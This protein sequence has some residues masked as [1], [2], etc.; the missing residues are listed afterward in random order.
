MLKI[1]TKLAEFSKP[2]RSVGKAEPYFLP[3][4]VLLVGFTAFGLGRLSVLGEGSPRLIIHMPDGTTQAA[5]VGKTVNSVVSPN[6]ATRTG[7]YVA[8]KSGTKY[9][10]PSCAGAA[11]IKEGNRVWFATVAEA[12]AA[13]YTA[14]ANC[15]GL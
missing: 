12:Q 6:Q 2:A 8:S 14:A 1:L 15:P 4:I 10:L 9:Y 5:A 7:V 3:A 13:G 11:R